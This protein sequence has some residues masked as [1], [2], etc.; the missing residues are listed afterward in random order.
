L[1]TSRAGAD[2]PAAVN[3]VL[4]KALAKTARRT[5]IRPCEEFSDALRKAFGLNSGMPTIPQV[6]QPQMPS[7]ASG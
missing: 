7:E 6:G 5:A 1:L 3:R 2:L 4:A